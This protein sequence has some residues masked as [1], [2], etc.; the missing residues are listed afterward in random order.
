MIL[1]GFYIDVTRSQ[2]K[3]ISPHNLWHAGEVLY[4][5]IFPRSRTLKLSVQLQYNDLLTLLLFCPRVEKKI[6]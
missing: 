5:Y 6:F 1:I 3:C 4:M 2:V